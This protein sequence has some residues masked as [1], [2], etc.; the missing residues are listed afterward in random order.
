MRAATHPEGQVGG[1]RRGV[2]VLKDGVLE[3]GELEA[4]GKAAPSQGERVGGGPRSGQV[5]DSMLQ[6]EGLS[7]IPEGRW[8]ALCRTG[9][10]TREQRRG[11]RSQTRGRSHLVCGGSAGTRQGR[12]LSNNWHR[13]PAR[14][15]TCAPDRRQHDAPFRNGTTRVT[16]TTRVSYRNWGRGSISP[17]L[18]MEENL[19]HTSLF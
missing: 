4:C 11:T 7:E 14:P 12:E 19:T 2:E 8:E 3:V 9:K 13:T 16:E 5:R 15:R 17:W 6:T 10:R 18:T 1:Q